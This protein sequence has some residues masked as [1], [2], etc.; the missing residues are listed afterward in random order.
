MKPLSALASCLNA[1]HQRRLLRRLIGLLA[2]PG[3][4]LISPAAH[5]MLLSDLTTNAANPTGNLSFAGVVFSD[6][7]MSNVLPSIFPNGAPPDIGSGSDIDVSVSG[8]PSSGQVTLN[9]TEVKPLVANTATTDYLR[10]LTFRA[11]TA[12]ALSLSDVSLGAPGF[13]VSGGESGFV[14]L[15]SSVL[16]GASTSFISRVSQ[17]VTPLGFAGLNKVSLAD[18]GSSSTFDA[19]WLLS[20]PHGGGGGGNVPPPPVG[21]NFNALQLTFTVATVPEPATTVMFGI[22]ALM[23][24]GLGIRRGNRA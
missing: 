8:N 4:I 17:T 11:S 22:G 13:V 15:Y 6:F 20:G 3:W 16:N 23:L 18:V 2:L 7:Q 5:A 9:F 1:P 10:N 19:E 14:A 21:G 24:L 12:A